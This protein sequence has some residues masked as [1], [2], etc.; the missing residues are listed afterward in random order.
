MQIILAVAMA[1]CVEQD[2]V[3]ITV[4]YQICEYSCR[5]LLSVGHKYP[6]G[7]VEDISR[8]ARNPFSA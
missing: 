7:G 3:E 6:P 4:W 2:R 8:E 1:S 5:L